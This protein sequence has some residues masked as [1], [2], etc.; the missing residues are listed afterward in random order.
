MFSFFKSAKEKQLEKLGYQ[1]LIES[2]RK[3]VKDKQ[4]SKQEFQQA[5]NALYEDKKTVL[6]NATNVN[7]STR[8]SF[9]DDEIM[10]PL[11][12]QNIQQE[13]IDYDYIYSS[14]LFEFNAHKRIHAKALNELT[15]FLDEHFPDAV[16]LENAHENLVSKS[17][18]ELINEAV[19]PITN[20][21]KNHIKSVFNELKNR[22]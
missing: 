15:Q 10:V 18:K 21:N 7:V 11:N 8:Q 1:S 13:Y 9:D 2:Y 14:L 20:E 12:L 3:K 4:W 5:L 17:L 16:L 22:L 19:L 6:A